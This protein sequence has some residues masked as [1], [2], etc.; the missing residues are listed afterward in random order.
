MCVGL[1]DLERS[2]RWK[3]E[4]KYIESFSSKNKNVDETRANT[5]KVWIS[6]VVQI[7][8]KDSQGM[9]VTFEGRRRGLN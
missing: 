6:K 8:A 1:Q 7:E 4:A 2:E 9:K 5:L 3:N